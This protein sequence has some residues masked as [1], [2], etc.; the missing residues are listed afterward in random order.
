MKDSAVLGKDELASEGTVKKQPEKQDKMRHPQ[1]IWDRILALVAG[2]FVLFHVYTSYMGPFPNLRQRAIHVCFALI[3]VFAF[4][5]P[6]GKKLTGS[7]RN[8]PIAADAVFI[9]ITIISCAYVVID[10]H[11]IMEHPAEITAFQMAVGLLLLFLVLE[12]GRRTVGILFPL[13][14]AFFILYAVAGQYIPDI[15]VIGDYLAYWGHRGFSF[16]HI[17]EVLYLSDKGIWGFVTGISSTLVAIFIIFGGVLLATGQG[18]TFMDLAICLTGR[19]YGGAAKVSTLASGFFGMMSGSAVANVVTTGNFTIPLMKRLKYGK[20]FAAGVESTASTGGQITPPIMGAGAFLMAEFLEIPYISVAIAAC[21]PAFL[22]YTAVF[23]AIHIESHKR[24][25]ASLPSDEIKPFKEV[26][27]PSRSI[28]LFIPIII[29]I[30]LMLSGRTPEW[31]AFWA[32]VSFAAIFVFSTLKPNEIKQR[33]RKLLVGMRTIASSLMKIVPLLVCANVIVSLISLTGLSVNMSE[34][35]ISISGKSAFLALGLAALVSLILGMGIPTPAAYLLG[36]SVVAPSLI[37]ME[38]TPLAAHMFVFYF[39]ILSAITP[40][41]CAGVYVASGI[42]GSE[43]L[44]TSWV[45]IRLSMV[46]YILPFIFIFNTS[47]LMLGATSDILWSVFVCFIGVLMLSAGV[48]GYL[49]AAIP[50][51]VRVAFLIGALLCLS[52]D[53]VLGSIGIAVGVGLLLFQIFFQK[54]RETNP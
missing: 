1:G 23:S 12:A 33:S 49:F 17:I 47:L 15:P 38:F 21:I 5:R 50:A 7:W 24:Q 34:M 25:M 35:I 44:K 41:V 6:F 26:M 16:E 20:E 18:E 27:K 39:A 8:I 28:P 13:L 32:T 14:T 22:F 45:A 4:M 36:A 30:S 42:A 51:L 2:A 37:E 48:M 43:W 52:T 53:P 46:T 31:S 9:I 10:Y 3:L 19:F 54:K 40:P 11:W 29:L